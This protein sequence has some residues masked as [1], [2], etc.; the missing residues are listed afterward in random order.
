MIVAGFEFTRLTRKP[1]LRSTRQ[2]WVPGESN[3]QAW[4]ITIG[5][6]PM[7]M[8]CWMSVRFGITGVLPRCPH[9]VLASE[10][11][12]TPRASPLRGH[13]RA[14]ARGVAAL[15][16]DTRAEAPLRGQDRSCGALQ[17]LDEA[18][19]EVGGVVRAGRRL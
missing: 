17:E 19:E 6:D 3:S 12:D 10:R 2:A 11:R 14:S 15:R 9:P 8:M 13:G 7:T 18:V 16:R 4:P 1:S 5:P